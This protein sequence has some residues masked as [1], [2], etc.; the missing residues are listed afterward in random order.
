MV[1]ATMQKAKARTA[2]LSMARMGGWA[3]ILPLVIGVAALVAVD[4]LAKFFVRGNLALSQSIHLLGFLEIVNVT[5][6]GSAFGTLKGT[7][8]YLIAIGLIAI[9]VILVAYT[10]FDKGLHRLGAAI[11]MA[12]ILGNTIDR[13]S[14]GVVTDFIYLKP[15]P[16]FNFADVLLSTG[17][18]IL[19]VSLIL[20]TTKA[21]A[22]TTKRTTTKRKAKR[23]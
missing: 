10:R 20:P 16:A 22:Q 1:T 21:A 17:L 3:D 6:T 23:N 12:G 15:W 9:V 11:I 5:N 13:V 2:T 7:Q 4:Q 18:V 14:T 8:P 19:L